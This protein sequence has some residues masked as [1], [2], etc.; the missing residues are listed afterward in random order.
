MRFNRGHV[1]N[2]GDVGKIAFENSTLKIWI[3]YYI[4]LWKYMHMT[5]LH[6][7]I[8]MLNMKILKIYSDFQ[9]SFL[10]QFF[11]K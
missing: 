4:N 10:G 9:H 5:L 1:R 6:C 8:V 7:V 2:V 3:K 11:L